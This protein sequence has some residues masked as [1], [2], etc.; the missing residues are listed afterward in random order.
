MGHPAT[1]PL[2]QY[3]E[4]ELR[5][6]QAIERYK[7]VQQRPFPTWRE[8]FQVFLSLGYRKGN[9]EKRDA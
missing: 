7:R 2:A 3:S 5:F 9:E 6:L 4:E 1:S 8:V